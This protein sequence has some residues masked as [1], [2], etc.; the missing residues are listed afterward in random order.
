MFEVIHIDEEETA[1]V[2]ALLAD[3]CLLDAGHCRVAVEYARKS[4]EFGHLAQGCLAHDHRMCVEQASNVAYGQAGGVIED[5]EGL[6]TTPDGVS[7]GVWQGCL[8]VDEV[9]LLDY[10]A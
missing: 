2:L 1:T 6:V 9:T 4:I 5:Y 3:E 10:L 8:D 7:L